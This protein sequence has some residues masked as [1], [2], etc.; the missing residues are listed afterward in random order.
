MNQSLEGI[1]RI[2]RVVRT[3]LSVV[4]LGML[5]PATFSGVI[6]LFAPIPDIAKYIIGGL[7]WIIFLL[8]W[9]QFWSKAKN[10]PLSASET[11][12]LHELKYKFMGDQEQQL[13]VDDQIW[14][15]NPNPGRPESSQPE[16]ES[17]IDK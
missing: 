13:T 15:L 6:I 9:V 3:P 2:V 5:I 10:E 8:V 7:P 12:Y 4:A 17:E 11:Y 1:A 16:E 14:G